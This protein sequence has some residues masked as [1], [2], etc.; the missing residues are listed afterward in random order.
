MLLDG[1]PLEILTHIAD[2]IL[3]KEDLVEFSE[4]CKRCYYAVLPHLWQQLSL[5]DTAE[6][7]LL[8]KKL[9]QN[10]IWAER[11]SYFV[12][13]VALVQEKELDRKYNPAVAASMF[14]IPSDPQLNKAVKKRSPNERIGRFGKKLLNMFPHMSSLVFDFREASKNFTSSEQQ[15]TKQDEDDN[16]KLPYSGSVSLIN[17]KSDSTQFMHYILS[18]FGKTQHLKLQASPVMS[19]CDDIDESILTEEDLQDLATLGLKDLKKL[20]L[21]YLDSNIRLESLKNLIENLPSIQELTIE[22]LFKPNDLEFKEICNLFKT[23]GSLELS[24]V[25]TTERNIFHAQFVRT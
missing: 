25:H 6:L 11:A 16:T 13:D 4:T 9:K 1:L 21:A 18:P 10:N 14:G 3:T 23:H 8:S 24:K 12:K 20:E 2:F 7:S 22:W 19:L 17:Y 5:H 15:S